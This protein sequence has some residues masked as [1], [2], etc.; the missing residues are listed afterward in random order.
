MPAVSMSVNGHAV[1]G[2]VEGRTM[3]VEF[4]REHWVSPARMSAA[5]Q[6]NA[7]PASCM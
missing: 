4:L 3:L 7:A 6:R 2:E 1:R 5:T